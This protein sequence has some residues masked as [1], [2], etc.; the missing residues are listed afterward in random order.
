MQEL[1]E[2]RSAPPHPRTGLRRLWR[3]KHIPLKADAVLTIQ[4]EELHLSKRLVR[5][6]SRQSVHCRAR[7]GVRTHGGQ[8]GRG[9]HGPLQVRPAG[10]GQGQPVQVPLVPC[11]RDRT[12]D[13]P[14]SGFT[15]GGSIP[16][17]T[18]MGDV[19]RFQVWRLFLWFF[20]LTQ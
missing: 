8:V 9:K 3:P 13:L 19:T 6:P 16:P 10:R 7:R 1:R 2:Q 4:Q 15:L 14:A 11:R 20:W 5:S 12:R 18:H 17:H